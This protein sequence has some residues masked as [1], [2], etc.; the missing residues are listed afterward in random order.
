MTQCVQVVYVL[1]HRDH[2]CTKIT[3]PPFHQAT[4]SCYYIG[5][6]KELRVTL[7]LP[8]TAFFVAVSIKSVWMNVKYTR[9]GV[10]H[11]YIYRDML[12]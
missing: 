4:K 10:F 12:C 2:T 7:E 3:R 5:P 11:V 9:Y 8:S 1:T 6:D